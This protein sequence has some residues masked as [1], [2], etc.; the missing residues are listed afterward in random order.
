VLVGR[1]LCRLDVRSQLG[2][3]P[4]GGA[5]ELGRGLDLSATA[6]T[7]PMAFRL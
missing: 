1:L 5:E 7:S 2:E 6:S 3:E 4:I